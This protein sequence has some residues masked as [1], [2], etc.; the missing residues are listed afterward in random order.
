MGPFSSSRGFQ[1]ILVAVDYVSTWVEDIPCVKYDGKS[2]SRFLKKILFPRFGIPRVIISDN[3][4]HFIEKK[5]ESLIANYGI[6]HKKGLP[7]HPQTQGQV[8]ISNRAIKEILEKTISSSRKDW[9][10]KLDEV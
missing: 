10:E 1:Y 2:V 6:N 8:E 5:F 4:S 3:G 9:V 7:Y